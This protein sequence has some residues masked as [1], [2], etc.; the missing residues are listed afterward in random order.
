MTPPHL[1]QRPLGPH[2]GSDGCLDLLHGLTPADRREQALAHLARCPT[3]E[4]LLRQA[5]A[6]DERLKARWRLHD[7]P[8]V[9]VL[10][11]RAAEGSGFIRRHHLRRVALG[12]A[13]VA[14][15][16]LLLRA[17]LATRRPQA[18]ILPLPGGVEELYQ[19]SADGGDTA[20]ELAAGLEAYRRAEYREA[21]ARLSDAKV[22]PSLETVRRL[23]LGSALALVGEMGRAADLLQPIATP[24]LPDPWG[25]EARWTLL[26]ALREAGRRTSADSLLTI[27]VEDPHELGQRARRLR[28]AG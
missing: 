7:H 13:A 18:V 24:S 27:L 9:G 3:C 23:Y 25:S 2:L 17:G 11:T 20:P 28:D 16:A 1:D 19:R 15:L 8:N 4:E 21:A 26:V 10:A 14:C 5:A 6:A 12:I 22:G